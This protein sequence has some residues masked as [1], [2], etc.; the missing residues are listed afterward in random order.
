[1]KYIHFGLPLGMRKWK[2]K[3]KQNMLLPR[4]LLECFLI[5]FETIFII[6]IITDS[7]L[8]KEL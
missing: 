2:N 5:E 8:R 1:M 3:T 6:M 7:L 4:R